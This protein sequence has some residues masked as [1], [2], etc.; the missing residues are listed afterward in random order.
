MKQLCL[1][2]CLTFACSNG[3]TAEN[4]LRIAIDAAWSPPQIVQTAGKPSGGLFFELFQQLAHNLEADIEWKVLPRKRLVGAIENNEA[5]LLCH[6]NPKWIDQPISPER[7]SG[8]FIEQENVI[9]QSADRPAQTLNLEQPSHFSL[10]TVLGFQ[11]PKLSEQFKRGLIRR[12][13]SPSQAVLLKNTQN[14][15]LA[16]SIANR[17]N[18]DYFNRHAAANEQLRIVQ[19]VDIQET[20]CLIAP[21]PQIPAQQIKAALAQLHQAK[22]VSAIMSR[23]KRK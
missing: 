21:R 11:Y 23:Y 9:I 10:G 14:G 6:V 7:W 15:K 1:W 12:I 4:T 17:L 3:F 22:Q 19:T 20:Y 16:Y 18:V 2:A 13:D 8:P 5:D